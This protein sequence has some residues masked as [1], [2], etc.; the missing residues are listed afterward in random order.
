MF[1]LW[2]FYNRV[3]G[4]WNGKRRALTIQGMK[5]EI[6]FLGPRIYSH[7]SSSD[8]TL[9]YVFRINSYLQMSAGQPEE[10]EISWGSDELPIENLNSKMRDGKTQIMWILQWRLHLLSE[11]SEDGVKIKIIP[12]RPVFFFS[13]WL[14]I[15]IDGPIITE[16][17][18]TSLPLVKVVPEG[19][20]TGARLNTVVRMMRG[21]LEQK[22]PLQEFD[23]R[24]SSEY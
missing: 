18:L 11:S 12:Y 6:S 17:E 1:C 14:L 20:Y 4:K 16:D 13:V 10:D 3:P 15:L 21:L 9:F 5:S 2:F 19:Q 24:V 22:V 23:V 8:L 7:L